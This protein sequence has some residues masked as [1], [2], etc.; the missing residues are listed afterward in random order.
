M[1]KIKIKF[2]GAKDNAD[3]IPKNKFNMHRFLNE[4]QEIL[5]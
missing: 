5:F 3:K 1:N 2:S 4:R